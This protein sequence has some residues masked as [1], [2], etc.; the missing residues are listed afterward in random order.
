MLRRILASAAFVVAVGS[1]APANA[2]LSA[3]SL[4]TGQADQFG[5]S[6][7]G[8]TWFGWSQYTRPLY[9]AKAEPLPAGGGDAQNLRRRDGAHTFFGDFD[10]GTTTA[11]FQDVKNAN[12]NLYLAD[13]ALPGTT[14]LPPDGVNTEDWEWAP[15][16]STNF[17]LFGRNRFTRGSSPWKVILY[18]RNTSGFRVLDKVENRCGC[19]WPEDVNERYVAWTKCVRRCNVWVFDTQDESLQKVPNPDRQQYAAAVSEEG[20]VYFVRSGNRCGSTTTIRAWETE[21]GGAATVVEYTYPNGTNLAWALDVVDG[22]DG[23]HDVYFDQASC[24]DQ[25]FR[26]DIYRIVDAHQELRPILRGPA[27]AGD[28]AGAGD[29]AGAW[30][31]P[32]RPGARPIG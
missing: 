14:S 2:G 23:F 28:A 10:P 11:I 3:E 9:T 30:R 1:V 24:S 31:G 29:G 21:V 22:M 6:A 7:D 32:E 16:M 12:S 25:S 20:R 5:P 18:D 27:G 8:D 26:G 19:I 17:I 15:E 4:K 13:L